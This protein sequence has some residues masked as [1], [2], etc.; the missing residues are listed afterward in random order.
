MSQVFSPSASLVNGVNNYLAAPESENIA[1]KGGR[2]FTRAVADAALS[3]AALLETVVFAALT[4]IA[5][6]LA[7]TNRTKGAYEFAKNHTAEAGNGFK[8]ALKGIFGRGEVAQ[9]E[10]PKTEETEASTG[11]VAALLGKVKEAANKVEQK[12]VVGSLGLAALAGTAGAAY[13]FSV[14]STLYNLA[15]QA[16][17]PYVPQTGVD[18]FNYAEDSVSA[19]S[20]KIANPGSTVSSLYSGAKGLVYPYTPQSV[21]DKFNYVEDAIAAI[22][23]KI[24][25][26]PSYVTSFFSK[27]DAPTGN[28]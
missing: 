2:V 20:S 18:A 12:H 25:S 28:E 24:A 7:L 15:K 14:P 3:V 6:P 4:V 10:A 1:H 22:P 23:S 13:Y 27:V 21:V 11:R 19:I 16:A 9:K 17:Y 5:S 8:N 26:I